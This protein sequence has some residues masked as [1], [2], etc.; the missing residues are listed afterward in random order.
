MAKIK[1][2]FIVM[3]I[4]F[5]AYAWLFFFGESETVTVVYIKGKAY[6][7]DKTVILGDAVPDGVNVKLSQGAKCFLQMPGGAIIKLSSRASME[8]KEE[9]GEK[10]TTQ[11]GKTCV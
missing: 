8:F 9:K 1:F 11:A 7:G 6:I 2:I 10:N 3:I 5:I 4:A